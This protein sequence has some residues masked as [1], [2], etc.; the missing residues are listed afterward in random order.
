MHIIFLGTRK[1]TGRTYMRT[2]D[3]NVCHPSVMWL[4]I[5]C[6]GQTE[7]LEDWPRADSWNCFSEEHTDYLRDKFF[8]RLQNPWRI[9]HKGFSVFEHS[10]GDTEEQGSRPLRKMSVQKRKALMGP[11]FKPSWETYRR[12][13]PCLCWLQLSWQDSAAVDLRPSGSI[14]KAHLSWKYLN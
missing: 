5:C 12:I 8:R 2:N 6:L 14:S 4:W 7:V 11:C 10:K 9:Q 3:E 13:T 1:H